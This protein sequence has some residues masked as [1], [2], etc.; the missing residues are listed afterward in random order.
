MALPTDRISLIDYAYRSLG[1]PVLEINVDDD[2][3]NDRLDEALQY[4]QEYHADATFRTYYK[5]QVTAQD[6]SNGF[7]TVPD[8]LLFV[9]RV[10]PFGD[11]NSSINMF[12]AR[13]QMMLNDMYQLNLM[14]NLSNYVQIQQYVSTIDMLLDGKEMIRFNRH[15]NELHIDTEWGKDVKEGEYVVIE[16]WQVVEPSNYPD[17]YNDWWLKRYFTALV[18]RQWGQNLLKFEGMQLPGGVMLNGRQ[19]FDDANNEIKELEEQLINDLYAPTD[20]FIG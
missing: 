16:G 14:G 11:A 8:A 18:K 15:M 19:L 7:I 1:A 12:D 5:H 9:Q 6:V 20:I 2:Q 4:W 13:Y 10:F 3:A 17:V